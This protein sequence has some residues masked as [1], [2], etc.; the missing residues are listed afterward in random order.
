ME[1]TIVVRAAWDDEA[2][3]WYVEDSDLHGLNLT[4]ETVEE[5]LSKLPAAIEDLFEDTDSRRGPIELRAVRRA[6]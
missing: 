2:Q 1:R 6:A 4:G 3:V 5:L